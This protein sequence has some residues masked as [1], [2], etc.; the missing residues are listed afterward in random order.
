MTQ[1]LPERGESVLSAL[2]SL[3]GR[4]GYSRYKMNKFEEYDLYA[5]NKDF[6]VS[7]S[8]ITFTDGNG[9]LL[10]LKPDVTL[11]IVKNTRDGVGVRKLYYDEN[12]YRVNKGSR[13]FKEI[14]QVGLECLGDVDAYCF[15]EVLDLAR[16]SLDCVGRP[17]LLAVSHLG[18]L[19]ELMDRAG[20]P[21]ER[22]AEAL[23]CVGE[24]NLHELSE[25]LAAVGADGEGAER[26]KETVRTQGTVAEVLPLLNERLAGW[27]SPETLAAV[28]AVLSPMAA[29]PT[30]QIDFSVVGDLHY[31]NGFVFKGFVEGIPVSVLSGGQY[32]TLMKKMGR[33]SRAVGFAVYL[34]AIEQ[35]FRTDEAYDAD[36]VLLYGAEETPAAV[37]AAV[38]SLGK[39]GAR[40]LAVKT[41][42]DGIRCKQIF[43][44][45]NGEVLTVEDRA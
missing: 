37:G 17:N 14:M 9:K 26:F 5:R 13:N 32:D 12:V 3:Y 35:F 29:V 20:I 39:N 18:L 42:P 38:A 19:S 25:L 33:S 22:K 11:S 27:V 34:D 24:K 16:Q 21:T 40:V 31:Y 23:R 30:A 43:R 2:R 15:Y 4:Y 28:T 7:E 1:T 41:L 10:A 44:L 45:R 36:T 6:L 8:V